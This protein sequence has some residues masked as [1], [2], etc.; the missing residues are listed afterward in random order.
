VNILLNLTDEKLSEKGLS[1]ANAPQHWEPLQTGGI[2]IHVPPQV[3]YFQD[4]AGKYTKDNAP[5]LFTSV[6]GDFVAQARVRPTFTS[7]YDAG[8]I[9]ARHDASRW[10]KLCFESTDLGTTAAVSV[11]TRR[12]SDDANGADLVLPELWLQICRVG[13]IFG[14]YYALDGTNWRMVRLFHLDT[15]PEIKVGLVAQSPI[16]PGT[17]VDFLHFS[18]ESRTINNLRSGT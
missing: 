12:L 7:T 14:M 5:Y 15:P 6:T 3:D 18:V 13:E 17:R 1:W 16:G 4:P 8:A 11:V 2:R 9:L 10:A